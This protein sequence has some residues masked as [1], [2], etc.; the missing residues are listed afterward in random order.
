MA[1]NGASAHGLCLE[2]REGLMREAIIGNHR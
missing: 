1:I 2:W